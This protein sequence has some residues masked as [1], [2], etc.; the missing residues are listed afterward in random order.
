ML[1]AVAVKAD[2]IAEVSEL[3]A[4]AAIAEQQAVLTLDRVAANAFQHMAS[5]YRQRAERLEAT[6]VTA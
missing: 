2:W 3:R 4:L 6:V 1:Y 5:G